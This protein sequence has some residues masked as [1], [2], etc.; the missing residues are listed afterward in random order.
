MRVTLRFNSLEAMREIDAD[1]AD[2]STRPAAWL[3][4][5]RLT[6][7]AWLSSNIG[8]AIWRPASNTGSIGTRGLAMMMDE[9]SVASP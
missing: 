3:H 8:I 5:G 7:C 1:H 4:G 9:Y 6:I 2:A